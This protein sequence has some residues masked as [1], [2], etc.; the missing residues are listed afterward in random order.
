[1]FLVTVLLGL[2]FFENNPLYFHTPFL[3]GPTFI[4]GSDIN[5]QGTDLVVD[6]YRWFLKYK[7]LTNQMTEELFRESEHGCVGDC[8]RNSSCKKGMCVCDGGLGYSQQ[9]GQCFIHHAGDKEKF[10]APE[11]P[12]RPDWCFMYARNE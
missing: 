3:M 5:H 4:G 10:R 7:G 6:I 8:P 11:S 9:Y 2:N 12:P 1:M